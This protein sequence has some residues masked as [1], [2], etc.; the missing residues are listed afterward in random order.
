MWWMAA[1]MPSEFDVRKLRMEARHLRELALMYENRPL[2][3]PAKAIDE[4]RRAVDHLDTA[5]T[6]TEEDESV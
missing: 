3:L 6:I 4:I 1:R 2:E 5:A